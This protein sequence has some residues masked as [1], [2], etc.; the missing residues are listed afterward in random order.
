MMLNP[1]KQH[2]FLVCFYARISS[3]DKSINE[4]VI[5]ISSTNDITVIGVNKVK[6]MSSPLITSVIVLCGEYLLHSAT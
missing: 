2:R 5:R 6:S 3:R 1:G 4:K